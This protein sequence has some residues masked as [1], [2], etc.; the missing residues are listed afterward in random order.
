MPGD[1]FES[2]NRSTMTYRT[3]FAPSP[4]GKL[5]IVNIRAAINNWLSAPRGRGS[6]SHRDTDLEPP[7]RRLV[8]TG[9]IR[10][11][12][13]A[14]LRRHAALNPKHPARAPSRN[15]RKAPGQARLQEDKAATGKG[16]CIIF[17]MPGTDLFHDEVKG[18]PVQEGRGSK[19]F[20]IGA[21]TARRVHLATWWTLTMGIT[22]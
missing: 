18:R 2:K 1:R 17:K 21:P 13:R 14:D 15:R 7:R 11:L 20:V 4:T 5:H 12:A 3:R 19:D 10:C 6:S 9:W 16:E 22:Q 8:Q